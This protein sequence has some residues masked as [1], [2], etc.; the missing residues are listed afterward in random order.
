LNCILQ[1]PIVRSTLRSA[2]VQVLGE[3]DAGNRPA[4]ADSAATPDI[5]QHGN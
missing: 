2:I 4:N 5:P 1:K 3:A